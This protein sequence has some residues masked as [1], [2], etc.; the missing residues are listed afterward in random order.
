MQIEE[1]TTR[2]DQKSS[3]IINLIRLRMDFDKLILNFELGNTLKELTKNT[4]YYNGNELKY[5]YHVFF[6]LLDKKGQYRN[7]IGKLIQKIEFKMRTGEFDVNVKENYDGF[8]YQETGYKE[9]KLHCTIYWKEGVLHSSEKSTK[10]D[11]RLN[12]ESE[13]SKKNLQF[14]FNRKKMVELGFV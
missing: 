5:Q 12:F 4:Q 7:M 10:L 3:K 2:K 13:L 9:I 11:W 14:I 1:V 8:R 6:K